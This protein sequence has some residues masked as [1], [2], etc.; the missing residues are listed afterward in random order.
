[1]SLK[2]IEKNQI[3]EIKDGIILNIDNGDL[4]ALK[5]IKENWN[6]RDESS[7]LRYALAVMSQAEDKILFVV[8][9]DGEKSG[10]TPGEG[11]VLNIPT[12]EKKESDSEESAP[13][14]EGEKIE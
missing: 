2:K 6:F 3:G 9:K 11:L 10:L 8:N 4:E 13:V 5:R 14:A 1:M 12:A 7:V